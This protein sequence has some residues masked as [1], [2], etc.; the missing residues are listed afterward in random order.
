M[1]ENTKNEQPIGLDEEQLQAITGGTGG[2]VSNFYHAPKDPGQYDAHMLIKQHER[3]AKQALNDAENQLI[4][5]NKGEA[6]KL[7]KEAKMH[8]DMITHITYNIIPKG[9][10]AGDQ[11]K[12]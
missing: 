10:V 9:S 8:Y 7:F 1:E 6:T 3:E 12:R 4:A 11:N 2:R 5:R